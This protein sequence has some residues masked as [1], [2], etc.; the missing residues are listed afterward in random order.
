MNLSG[1]R[2]SST[3]NVSSKQLSADNRETELRQQI[4]NLQTKK[5]D[6]SNDREKTS[7]EKKK[8]KQAVQEEIQALNN[9]L[10]QYQI[11]K[12]Q[13]EAAKKQEAM[14]EAAKKADEQDNDGEKE[15]AAA[16][17]GDED[18]GVLLSLSA[19]KKQILGMKRTMTLLERK[20]GSAATEEEKADFQK[21]INNAARNIGK[22]ITI[23][24]GDMKKSRNT[25]QKN[26]N[27][28]QLADQPFQWKKQPEIFT[29]AD[30]P[31]EPYRKNLAA[32]RKRFFDTVS[33]FL[34]PSL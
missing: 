29:A 22:K 30:D 18:S 12:R 10:R 7:E 24:E 21:R 20:Q 14:K 23:T 11:E 31:E 32:N 9:E 4:T 3:D 34:T 16:V 8:E 13:E 28:G 26:S 2:P 17:F 1:I 27:A 15:P 19:A 33:V 5:K 25:G 6:I